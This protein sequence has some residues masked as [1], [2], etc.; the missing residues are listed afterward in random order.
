[1]T[2]LKAA[3]GEIAVIFDAD[4]MPPKGIIRNIVMA[5]KDPEI[6]AVMGRVIPQNSETNLLTKLLTLERSAGYQVDQQAR[7]NLG[8]IPQ[9]GGTVGG[10][11]RELVLNLGGFDPDILTEDT[12]LTIKLLINGWKVAY[13]NRIECYEEVPE[14]WA[15][16]ARQVRR[17]SRG[18]NQVMYKYLFKM[19]ASTH[20]SFWAKVDGVLLQCIYIIPLV[21]GIGVLDAIAL[22]FMGEVQIYEGVFIFLVVAGF[23]VFGNFA[24]FYQIGTASLVDGFDNRVKL[25]PFILF[26]FLFN[27]IHSALGAIDALID[28][29]KPR[30]IVWEKTQ[31]YRQSQQP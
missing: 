3:K 22:F 25:L 8:L 12:E 28:Q 9:Y 29:F 23:N 14:D 19:L 13:N 7:Q 4:Y 31:R 2:L 26:N 20:I 1:M 16:R 15:T 27:M 24:P 17:W 18:H 10:F 6:G 5:F 11:R 21:L 30:E